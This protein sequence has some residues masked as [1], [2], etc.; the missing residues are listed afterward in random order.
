MAALS[1]YLE[2]GLLHHIFRGETFAKPPEIAIA[3]TS[4]NFSD[5]P[6]TPDSHTG[7]NITELSSGDGTVSSNYSRVSLGD[8]ATNENQWVYNADDHAVGSGVIRNSGQIVFPTALTDWGW[9]SGVAILDTSNYAS[10]NVLMHAQLDNPRQIYTG[11]NVKFDP[12]TLEISF[13]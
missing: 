8:P 7:A 3:L 4:G 9:V 13:K 12:L 2:S 6:N 10:G 5:A 11:D 1:D